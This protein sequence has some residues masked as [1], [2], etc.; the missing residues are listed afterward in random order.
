MPS[1]FAWLDYSESE[2]RKMLDVI[3]LFGERATRDELGLG[4]VRDA[5][6]DLLFPGTST[7]QTRAR[8]FL[9]VPWLYL[10]LER[11]QTPSAKA[12]QRGREF[13]ARLMRAVGESG[14]SKG[15]IG[16]V[17]GAS[18]QRLPS[19]V[20]WQGLAVWGLRVSA[21]SQAEY[22]R[23]LDAFYVRRRGRKASRPDFD[24]EAEDDPDLHNWHPGLPDP[25][26]GFPDGASFA[27]TRP[28]A[29]YLRDRVLH[30]CPRSLLAHLLRERTPVGDFAWAWDLSESVP[31]DLREALAHGR[32]FSEALHGAQLLYNLVLAEAKGHEE[33]VDGYREELAEWRVR[34]GTR[35]DELAG[36]DLARF[37]AIVYRQNP[38]VSARATGFVDRWVAIVRGA[39]SLDALADDESARELVKRREV[40]L[41]GALA[42]TRGGRPLEIWEGRS[43]ADQ[44]DLRWAAA[45]RIVSDVLDGLEAGADA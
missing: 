2:R 7:I 1:S 37:W 13:E 41:K 44:I 31:A 45:R 26:P 12:A 3:E 15:L 8:Y 10:E 17:A 25:P 42:R 35:S 21:G 6:A 11:K 29:A 23:S 22:H 36:W 19:S 38:R 27:L 9:F 33:W 16:R 34:V 30:A 24:G 5:F 28:E 14:D 18:V 20:Y 43:G 4:G 39:A 32:N 40:Q